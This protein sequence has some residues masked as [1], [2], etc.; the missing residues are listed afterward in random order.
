MKK[1][2]LSDISCSTP[3]IFED[4]KILYFTCK[5]KESAGVNEDSLL[6]LKPTD[7]ITILAVAD[8][9]GGYTG[10]EKA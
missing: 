8:G 4:Y 9:A 5:N 7:S 1:F 10:G 2:L 6:I 3:L